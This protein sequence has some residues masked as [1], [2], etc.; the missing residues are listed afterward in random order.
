[1][2]DANS[3]TSRLRGIV[4]NLMLTCS[5]VETK[6]SVHVGDK[7]PFD[8]LLG[9]PWQRGNLVTI[10]EREEGTYLMSKDKN[11]EV[12][13]ELLVTP[14]KYDPNDL[15]VS[16]FM[17]KIRGEKA[18]VNAVFLDDESKRT[19][20]PDEVGGVRRVDPTRAHRP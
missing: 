16:E 3:G 19:C 9:R 8:L 5:D 15:E 14:E 11:F 1:M 10:D 6:A 17:A 4:K 13:H 2:N 18:A 20:K 7:V 12:T